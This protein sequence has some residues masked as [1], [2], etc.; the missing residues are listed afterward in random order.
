MTAVE[1][2]H[3]TLTITREAAESE[4]PDLHAIVDQSWS[5]ASTRPVIDP[6]TE[7]TLGDLPLASSSDIEAVLASAASASEAWA[8]TAAADRATILHR[9][10]ETLRSNSD[11]VAQLITLEEGK[12]LLEA[13]IDVT[14]A[15]DNLA[16]FA[17]EAM[18]V[19]GRLIPPR[20]PGS[21]AAVIYEPIGPVVA[22]TPWNGP[23][24]APARKIAT[25]L[26]AG[27][28]CVIKPAEEAPA[29]ALAVAEAL[30]EAGLPDGTL[31]MIFGE[32]GNVAA[33]VV[34]SPVIRGVSFTGSTRIGQE[35]ARLA[36]DGVKRLTLELGGHAPVL[37]FEDADVEEAVALSIVSKFERN[38][39][40]VCISPSRFFVAQTRY[41]EF[42]TRF[43][44]A[45]ARL[46]VGDGFDPE[47]DMGPL[48]TEG[49]VTAMK[50]LVDDARDVGAQV[51]VGG[52][53]P[54]RDGFF[55]NLRFF[56]TCQ[57]TPG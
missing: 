17:G 34:Q 43:A 27:C 45:T 7:R 46:R 50:A 44:E 9:A 30:R 22:F 48:A 12:R 10:S 56:R 37:V 5:R 54:D 38:A 29:S 4:Y 25:A 24:S 15:A 52:G 31:G 36:A 33:Q 26:A 20:R 14:R 53:I 57:P 41:D 13:R 49:R 16:W 51:V 55:L 35:I 21:E 6:S 19:D 11:R 2:A 23:V 39:G 3:E 1:R 32:P 40:Q 8:A 28:S 18:R 42:V 47:V